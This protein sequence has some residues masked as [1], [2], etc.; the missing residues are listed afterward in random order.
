MYSAFL[1]RFQCGRTNRVA[2]TICNID[3]F[4]YALSYLSKRVRY[5]FFK[6]HTQLNF[7]VM[8]DTNDNK[9]EKFYIGG[10]GFVSIEEAKLLL[11]RIV[12]LARIYQNTYKIKKCFMPKEA[13]ETRMYMDGLLEK[14]AESIVVQLLTFGGD[15]PNDVNP[16]SENHG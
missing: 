11:Q 13:E 16:D 3:C 10:F 9:K 15:N 6:F 4:L 2:L 14:Q 8:N 12:P 5:K 1:P 7:Q